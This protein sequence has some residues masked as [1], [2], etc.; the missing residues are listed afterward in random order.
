VADY[1]RTAQPVLPPVIGIFRKRDPRP[2]HLPARKSLE[3][4]IDNLRLAWHWAVEYGQ[5]QWL[6]HLFAVSVI[7]WSREL[8]IPN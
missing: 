2:W 7:S 4:E 1:P 5:Y 8:Y 3:A 6:K